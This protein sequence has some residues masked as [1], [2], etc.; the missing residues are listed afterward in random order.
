MNVVKLS[1]DA[2]DVAVDMGEHQ[3]SEFHE[4][5]SKTAVKTFNIALNN[6]PS[7]LNRITYNSA[8]RD[9]RTGKLSA[10]GAVG[11]TTGAFDT[12]QAGNCHP[13][14]YR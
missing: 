11:V 4:T 6:C 7:G 9:N 2:P 14:R 3:I 1:C 10:K 12:T 13:Y 8:S 5:G